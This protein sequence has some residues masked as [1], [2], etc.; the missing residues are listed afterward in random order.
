MP[1]MEYQ[2]RNETQKKKKSGKK[3]NKFFG[4]VNR[5]KR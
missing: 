3:K 1:G 4:Y 5:V 2:K